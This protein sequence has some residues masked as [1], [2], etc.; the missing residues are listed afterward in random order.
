MAM[1]DFAL[2]CFGENTNAAP[3]P[4]LTTNYAVEFPSF[5]EIEGGQHVQSAMD[6]LS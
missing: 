4:R 3:F 6:K 1:L 5:G 2:F